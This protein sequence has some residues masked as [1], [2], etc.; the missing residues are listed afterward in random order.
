MKD[1]ESQT[2]E[3]KSSFMPLIIAGGVALFLLGLAI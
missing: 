3:N 1:E 2:E